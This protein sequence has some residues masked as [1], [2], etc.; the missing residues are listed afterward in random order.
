MTDAAPADRPRT[1]LFVAGPLAPGASVA[2]DEGR[3]HYLRNVLRMGPGDAVAVFDGAS[4]EWRAEV[5]EL[6]KRGGMLAVSARLRAQEPAPDLW[7]LAAP[8]ARARYEAV[9]EKAT[10]LGVS[11]IVPVLTARTQ[12]GRVNTDRLRAVAVEAA[13][14][15]ERLDVPEAAEPVRLDALLR[16][17]PDGRVLVACTEAGPVRPIA[18][19]AAAVPR[20][21]PAAILVG[22]EGGFTQSELDALRGSHFCLAVGLGPRVLRAD[23]AAVAALACWQALAEGG[24][25]GGADRRPPARA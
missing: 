6:W 11:R 16:G 20:G 15:C 4:G 18:E 25:G 3:A 21:T 14:Q 10:E 8:I 9:A 19:A 1:R 12:G 2:L 22:P 23:T 5:A 13:E 17:W 7:L 24:P